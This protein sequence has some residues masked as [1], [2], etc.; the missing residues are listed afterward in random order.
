MGLAGECVCAGQGWGSG[1]ESAG[2]AL[3]HGRPQTRFFLMTVILA[4]L[5]LEQIGLETGGESSV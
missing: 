1:Y 4:K 3:S 2:S 5:S